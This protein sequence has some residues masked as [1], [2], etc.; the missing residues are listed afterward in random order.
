MKAPEVRATLAS[1]NDRRSRA[2]LESVGD[3]LEE[4]T[5]H[6]TRNAATESMP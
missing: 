3:A 1:H 6:H 5:V 4:N 2:R